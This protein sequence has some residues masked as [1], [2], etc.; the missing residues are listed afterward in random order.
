MECKHI[1]D[2]DITAFKLL[3]MQFFDSDEDMIEFFSHVDSCKVCSAK[4]TMEKEQYIWFLL[5]R[6]D[7]FIETPGFDFKKPFYELDELLSNHDYVDEKQYRYLTMVILP[8]IE[9]IMKGNIKGITQE[10]L[11]ELE[12]KITEE[13]LKGLFYDFLRIK[14]NL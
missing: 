1:R 6:V 12:N 8:K 2:S 10:E 7:K 11:L 14:Y 13:E 5:K 4:L 9:N 3:G